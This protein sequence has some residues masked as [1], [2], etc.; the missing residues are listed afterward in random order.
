M[1]P[2]LVVV[3]TPE[4]AL[5]G[6]DVAV[7]A[8]EWPVYRDLDWAAARTAMRRALIIDG[9]RLLSY[10]RLR[11][12]GYEVLRLGDGIGGDHPPRAGG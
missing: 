6:A 11:D 9:R 1:L 12:L 3:S 8:T 5:Q 7:I 2:N 4:E 10:E